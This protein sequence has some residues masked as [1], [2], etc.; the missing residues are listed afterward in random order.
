MSDKFDNGAMLVPSV[1]TK[2]GHA[3]NRLL[4]QHIETLP[5]TKQEALSFMQSDSMS[6]QFLLATPNKLTT[7]PNRLLPEL[8]AQFLGIPSPNFCR[9]GFIGKNNPSPV[10]C[11]GNNVAARGDLP[12]VGFK[13]IH[14][15]VRDVVADLSRTAGFHTQIEV[16]NHFR[17][18]IPATVQ[19][20]YE[21]S[22]EAHCI[23]GDVRIANYP[24]SDQQVDQWT[25]ASTRTMPALFEIKTI[26]M[27]TRYDHRCAH[28]RAT[29]KRGNA[30]ITEY[31]KNAYSIDKALTP[32]D[33]RPTFN[34]PGTKG[35]FEQALDRHA[36]GNVIPLV[37]GSFGETNK[38]LDK[39]ISLLGTVAAK[40]SYG[41]RL[42]P[43]PIGSGR[44]ADTLLRQQFRRRLGVEIACAY[45][46]VKMERLQYIGSTADEARNLALGQQN[47]R[48]WNHD[49]QYP[50][51]FRQ[52]FNNACFHTWLALRQSTLSSM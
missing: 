34:G 1:T 16:M 32:N 47:R 41:M 46:F 50:S 31:R 12:G 20:L 43:H 30:V 13:Y 11:Y 4:H 8:F 24:D 28:E 33:T 37:V 14:D 15:T 40:T 9:G 18:F 49:A 25:T 42:S 27:G 44:G 36:T 35:P 7:I 22:T 45:A 23:R 51:S 26:R 21:S 19:T 17:E 38:T 2:L 29:D 6:W 10:D 5:K 48:W 3:Y 39:L 52:S